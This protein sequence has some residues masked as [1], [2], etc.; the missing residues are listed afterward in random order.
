MAFAITSGGSASAAA[1]S[2]GLPDRG[3]LL[4][5]QP[6]ARLAEPLL[7]P[8]QLGVR[9]PEDRRLDGRDLDQRHVDVPLPQ[10]EPQR[11]GDGPDPELRRAV[12]AVQGKH[13]QAAD[14]AHVHDPPAALPDQR[15]E[16]LD[17]RDGA[18]QVDL[19]LRAGSRPSAGTRCGAGLAIPALLTRPARPRSPTASATVAAAAEIVD[20]SVTSTITGVSLLRLPALAG[21][22]RPPPAARRRRRETRSRR[23]G[24]RWRRRYPWR[25]P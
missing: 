19:E 18:E 2:V 5:V 1:F 20:S 8:V 23:G 3:D 15:Q 25:C 14:R 7:E 6:V 13:E 11:V 4:L 9:L 17:H 22:R 21:P 12:G 24:A 10:L 16:R